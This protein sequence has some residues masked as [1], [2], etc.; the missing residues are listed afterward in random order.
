LQQRRQGLVAQ[1]RVAGEQERGL[2]GTRGSTNQ[3]PRLGAIALQI[4]RVIEG[5]E[6]DV[7][8]GYG[9]SGNSDGGSDAAERAQAQP[10]VAA[11]NIF[12]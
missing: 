4:A 3:G 5:E 7:E 9:D 10:P 1:K 11:R 2:A 12:S 8:R 6:A